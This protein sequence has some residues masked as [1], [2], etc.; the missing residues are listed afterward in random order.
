MSKVFM[1]QRNGELLVGRP[2][3]MEC[4]DT[5]HLD[6]GGSVSLRW[7]KHIGYALFQEDVCLYIL[8]NEQI[9]VLPLEGLGEL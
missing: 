8:T 9:E 2:I 7:N 4:E 6:T 5:E 1:S 3:F